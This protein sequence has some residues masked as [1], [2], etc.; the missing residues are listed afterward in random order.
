MFGYGGGP[1]P[2]PGPG[3]AP[4]FASSGP[5]PYQRPPLGT[6]L[7]GT[8][9]SYSAKGFGFILCN[10]V[11]HDVYFARESLQDGLRTAN[12]AGTVVQF[13]LQRGLHGKPQATCLRPVDG[14]IAPMAYNRG[15]TPEPGG[16]SK[17]VAKGVFSSPPVAFTSFTPPPQAPG[18]GWSPMPRPPMAPAP[19]RLSPH[20]GSRAI[21]GRP[22][23]AAEEKSKSK[24]E[25]SSASPARESSESSSSE[26]KRKKKD[27]KKGRKDR[28][29]SRRKSRSSSRLSVSS[30]SREDKSKEAP[31]S[32]VQQ[33]IESAKREVLQQLEN[34]KKVEP[35]EQRMKE[36]RS[37][38]RSWHPDKNPEKSEVATAVFQF[39]QKGKLLLGL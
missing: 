15:Y 38:L 11:D 39:L 13:V 10:D 20:A 14:Q 21:A 7:T 37:L 25:S 1:A 9:K 6:V 23:K 22:P 26:R 35:K 27:K 36:W 8:V 17:G 28:S 2:F 12:I 33:E 3:G 16:G 29:R 18:M 5:T 32:E 30:S 34:L 24:S 19:K 31:S 4:S